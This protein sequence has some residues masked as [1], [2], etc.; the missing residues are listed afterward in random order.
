MGEGLASEE[1]RCDELEKSSV[2]VSVI[3]ELEAQ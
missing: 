3:A 1:S 2:H